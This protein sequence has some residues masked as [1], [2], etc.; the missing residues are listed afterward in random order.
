MANACYIAA[1]DSSGKVWLTEEFSPKP[2]PT[3][4]RE[5]VVAVGQTRD[6]GPGKP[7]RRVTQVSGTLLV[8]QLDI[9]VGLLDQSRVDGLQALRDSGAACEISLD[10][11]ATRWLFTWAKDGCKPECW[12]VDSSR[13]KALLKII[14]LGPNT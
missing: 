14:P 4:T 1:A 3:M 7:A 11:G 12:D 5:A 2:F 13:F 10:G 6:G 8:E 9:P